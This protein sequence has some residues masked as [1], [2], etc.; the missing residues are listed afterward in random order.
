MKHT[1]ILALL[2]LLC[3]ACGQK[4]P[5]YLPPPEPANA[6]QDSDEAEPEAETAPQQSQPKKGPY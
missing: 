2:A 1:S 6:S 3:V 4:G 5:L